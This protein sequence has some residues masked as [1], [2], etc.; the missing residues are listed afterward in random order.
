[1]VRLVTLVMRLEPPVPPTSSHATLFGAEPGVVK[2]PPGAN[3]LDPPVALDD[4]LYDLRDKS[5]PSTLA[6]IAAENAYA[7]AFLE[8]SNGWAAASEDIERRLLA[9]LFTRYDL[10]TF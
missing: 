1:M 4:P 5:L 2:G 9:F 7:D 10:V 8:Q 6:H 3:L